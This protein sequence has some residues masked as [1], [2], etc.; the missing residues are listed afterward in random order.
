MSRFRDDGDGNEMEM[1]SSLGEEGSTGLVLRMPR[2]PVL[3]SYVDS[4]NTKVKLSRGLLGNVRFEP[5]AGFD[6]IIQDTATLVR[7]LGTEDKEIAAKELDLCRQEIDP[8]TYGISVK[9]QG[10]RFN[11]WCDSFRQSG[12]RTSSRR[13]ELRRMAR[14]KATSQRDGNVLRS[15]S[16]PSNMSEGRSQSGTQG[17]TQEGTEKALATAT[18]TGSPVYTNS[19]SCSSVNARVFKAVQFLLR[20]LQG[21]PDYFIHPQL[22]FSSELGRRYDDLKGAHDFLN[23]KPDFSLTRSPVK[24]S[25]ELPLCCVELK[26][27]ARVFWP[28]KDSCEEGIAEKQVK[29]IDSN[30]GNISQPSEES[31]TST[32]IRRLNPEEEVVSTVPRTEDDESYSAARLASFYNDLF[33]VGRD[34]GLADVRGKFD[35]F[36]P[37]AQT[38]NQ[39]LLTQTGFCALYN[40]QEIVFFRIQEEHIDAKLSAVVSVSDVYPL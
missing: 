20:S 8:E 24:R 23:I 28:V 7:A 29:P 15:D 12:E 36:L 33:G 32:K 14:L 6:E 27:P 30:S 4:S 21:Q 2:L 40:H 26:G 39:G 13:M 3:E 31:E 19:T 37:I 9:N 34:I 16:D 38:L 25:S 5:W 35:T 11:R 17:T 1:F 10:A 22:S 18:K